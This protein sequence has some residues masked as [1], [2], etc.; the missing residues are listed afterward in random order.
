MKLLT[1]LFIP[2]TFHKI[3]TYQTNQI[4]RYFFKDLSYLNKK[5]V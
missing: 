3:Y 2:Y 1:Y 5:K 4:T